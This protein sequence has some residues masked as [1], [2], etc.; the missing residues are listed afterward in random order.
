[1]TVD[2]M[3]IKHNNCLAKEV[4][5]L[6]IVES[7]AKCETIKRY[8][9]DQYEVQAS[10]GHVRDLATKGKGGLGVDVDHAFAPTYIINKKKEKVVNNLLSLAKKC[11]EVILATDPDREGEAIAWHLAAVLN[12]NPKTTKRLEFHE[13]TR[14][15]ITN[16]MNNPR[17]IDEDLVSSQE[18][19]R[20]LDRIIGFKLSSLLKRSI[21]SQSGGRVQSATLRLINDHDLEIEQFVPEEYWNILTSIYVGDQPF[22]LSFIG[23]NGKETKIKNEQEANEIF[24]RIGDN[25][26]V[27]SIKK[28]L[29]KKEAKEPF[30][31]ST[32][33]Q[34]AFNR[35]KISTSTAQ[36]LAQK[37][38]EGIEV[39]GE[40]VGLITYIRTDSTRLSTTFI[41]R[42]TNYITERFG[43]EYVND[44]RKIKKTSADG[45]HE[46]IRPTSN[47]RTP[48]S[49]LNIPLFQ[50]DK[51]LYKLYKLIY[52]RAV[53]SLMKPA[54]DEVITIT[55][56]NNDLF[57]KLELVHN[58]FKGYEILLSDLDSQRYNG[59]LPDIKEGDVFSLSKKNKEQKFTQPPAHYSEAKL[60]KIME[61]VGIGRPSTYVST[62]DTLKRRK[63]I[64]D[65]AGVITITEQ[66]KLTIEYLKEFFAD[67]V[68]TKY[69][70]KM[71]ENLDKIEEGKTK[72]LPILTK[73]YEPFIKEFENAKNKKIT[74][75]EICPECG[76]NLMVVHG[77]NGNFVGCSNY[78]KCHYVK[79]KPFG[80]DLIAGECP[81]CGKPLVYR[82]KNGKKFIGC[83]NYPHCLYTRSLQIKKPKPVPV[84]AC[85]KC[86]GSL[87]ERYGGGKRFLGCTNYP[88]CNYVEALKK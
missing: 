56:K 11:D 31:T 46:A 32:L 42:S 68:D 60:V 40:H 87:V 16:A 19:R 23:V 50:K 84:K 12:L 76:S 7:P 28:T 73:F 15:S 64:S 3:K 10:Y 77:R 41:N 26:E 44:A 59:K 54:I 36:S 9:G 62:L 61:E 53:A 47:H 52:N 22:D 37:L 2:K 18:T 81:E 67:I 70:A 25:F 65:K 85:P 27:V 33:Q 35:L 49:L 5:K 39:N 74:L 75:D 13:I 66:G 55:L 88:K 4:M 78:P 79:P 8:L 30:T 82:E 51:N 17:T 6:V 83:T 43:S 1:M 20:I 63:Y 29:R 24:D 57:F 38:Y 21:K 86:G 72:S 48:E 69:T 80:E 14:D 71:E 34:E 45:P 58:V